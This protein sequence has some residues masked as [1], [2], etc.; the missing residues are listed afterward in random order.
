MRVDV[1]L[2]FKS[3][4][5][6]KR[7]YELGSLI[8]KESQLKIAHAIPLLIM[9]KSINQLA[10]FLLAKSRALKFSLITEK[11]IFSEQPLIPQNASHILFQGYWQSNSYF[12]ENEDQIKLEIANWLMQQGN[13]KNSFYVDHDQEN[14]AVGIRLYSES[15]DPGFHARDGREKSIEEFQGAV[16]KILDEL[17][18]PVFHIFSVDSEKISKAINFYGNCVKYVDQEKIGN[19]K[20]RMLAFASSKHFIFNN[21]TFYWWGAYLAQSLLPLSSRIIYSSDNFLN[22]RSVVDGWKIF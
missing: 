2:G 20:Q 22:E 1:N 21:S 16:N 5:R 6:Y 19:S 17:K 8:K 11:N 14:V 3:D 15:K 10:P 12:Q 18:N 9:E 4:F 7:N 13:A